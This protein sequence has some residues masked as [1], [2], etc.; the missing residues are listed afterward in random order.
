MYRV[1]LVQQLGASIPAYT[2]WCPYELRTVPAALRAARAAPHTPPA[3]A[4]AAADRPPAVKDYRILRRGEG[5]GRGGGCGADHGGCAVGGAARRGGG[6]YGNM[7][8]V[9]LLIYLNLENRPRNCR[10]CGVQ[11]SGI[12]GCVSSRQCVV[13]LIKAV[14]PLSLLRLQFSGR[15]APRSAGT[16]G[17][18]RPCRR[19][20]PP[21]PQGAASDGLPIPP[22]P[23]WPCGRRA[24]R[25]LVRGRVRVRVRVRVGLGLGLGARV[26][27]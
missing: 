1:F 8:N 17:T 23:Q 19:W 27:G 7:E 12:V 3:A 13:S 10:G 24:P 2:V 15:V 14:E 5:G 11:H 21:R 6:K 18:V 22:P 4:G 20:R 25:H 16:R 26:R 9:Q